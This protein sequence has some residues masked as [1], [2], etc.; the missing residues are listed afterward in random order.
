MLTKRETID[1]EA[2]CREPDKKR[3]VSWVRAMETFQ[4]QPCSLHRR[5]RQACTVCQE[6]GWCAEHR[7]AFRECD[8]CRSPELPAYV[9]M[10]FA[11]LLARRSEPGLS[12]DDYLDRDDENY[13]EAVLEL[14]RFFTST[15]TETTSSSAGGRPSRTGS[16]RS[17]DTTSTSASRTAPGSE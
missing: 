9:T 7:T 1:F 4:V 15:Q 12:F 14:T 10:P 16:R 17:R 2:V 3:P 6:S 13:T 5:Q 11:W 8:E